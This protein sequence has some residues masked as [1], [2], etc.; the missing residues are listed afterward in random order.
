MGCVGSCK[1]TS[2]CFALGWK[3]STAISITTSRHSPRSGSRSRSLPD[4][5]LPLPTLEFTPYGKAIL[6]ALACIYLHQS[7][8]FISHLLSHW[9]RRTNTAHSWRVRIAHSAS[10][11]TAP[12]QAR[13]GARGLPRAAR[14]ESC[15]QRPG[16]G[17]HHQCPGC[18]VHYGA[19]DSHGGTIPW[20]RTAGQPGDSATASPPRRAIR[21]RRT[22][23]PPGRGSPP[24]APSGPDR[25]RR[26]SSCCCTCRRIRRRKAA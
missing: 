2:E 6:L 15:F 11:G 26:G 24:A 3:S 19:D 7:T 10:W 23:A 25:Q 14:R 1:K 4:C 13:A 21:K 8:P 9:Q 17:Q 5:Q 22:F 16:Q 12:G 20:A 18:F